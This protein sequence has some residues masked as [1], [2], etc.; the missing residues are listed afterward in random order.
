[1]KA[2]LFASPMLIAMGAQNSPLVYMDYKT[3]FR[4]GLLAKEFPT[5]ADRDKAFDEYK[6]ELAEQEGYAL[7]QIEGS[8]NSTD[9][10]NHDQLQ[11]IQYKFEQ[12]NKRIEK[13]R[14]ESQ[15]KS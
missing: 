9:Q 15:I 3:P 4:V 1:M 12:E 6:K 13:H 8:S 14:Q 7:M 2:T 5:A 11:T 10:E